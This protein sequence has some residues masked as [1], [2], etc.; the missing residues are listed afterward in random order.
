MRALRIKIQNQTKKGELNGKQR[1][2]NE[3]GL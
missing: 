3:Q 1:K 2:A